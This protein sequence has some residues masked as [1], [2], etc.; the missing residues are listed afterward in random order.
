MVTVT[1]YGKPV[2]CGNM[3]SPCR[4]PTA[5]WGVTCAAVPEQCCSSEW[6]HFLFI[7]TL[8]TPL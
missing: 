1:D 6:G 3:A 7:I 4:P 5:P 8:S 2:W